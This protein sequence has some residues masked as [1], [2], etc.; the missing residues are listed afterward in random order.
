MADLDALLNRIAAVLDE[1]ALPPLTDPQAACGHRPDATACPDCTPPDASGLWDLRD[2]EP[3]PPVLP[4]GRFGG[5]P[6][7][8]DE[9]PHPLRPSLWR[10]WLS[11]G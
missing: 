4:S 9:L 10:R 7:P 1:P 2:G 8:A 11:R 6:I 5:D 3:V